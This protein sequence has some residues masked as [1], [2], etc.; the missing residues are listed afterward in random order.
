[1]KLFTVIEIP[2]EDYKLSKKWALNIDGDIG[3]LDEDGDIWIPYKISQCDYEL[4]PLPRRLDTQEDVSWY[5]ANKIDGWNDCLREI[6][7]ET[8]CEETE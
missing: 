7:G 3:Y 5:N 1:M 6:T 8:E 4:R 2:D